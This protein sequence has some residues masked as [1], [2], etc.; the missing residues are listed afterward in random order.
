MIEYVVVAVVIVAGLS[1]SLL[2]LFLKT[3]VKSNVHESIR[4]E[5]KTNRLE[6]QHDFDLQRQSIQHQMEIERQR[7]A[8]VF[9]DK[10]NELNRQDK[11]RLTSLEKRM[12]AHQKAFALARLLHRTVHSSSDEKRKVWE[13]C[14]AF[15][16]THF[17]YLT[18]EGRE[19]FWKALSNH[20]GY[21]AL[22]DLWRARPSN[23]KGTS[24][25][26]IDAFNTI[27]NLPAILLSIVDK[28]ALGKGHSF[29]DDSVKPLPPS[30][31]EK[32]SK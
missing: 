9:E 32:S 4:D 22:L 10:W 1:L 27:Q 3:S 20:N 26:L 18:D 28:E 7:N 24:K 31:T 6:I 25:E 14:D 16:N 12:E 8:Q 17:L 13:S 15:I 30:E 11:F 29:G 5:F 2:V 19:A 21:A 23:E